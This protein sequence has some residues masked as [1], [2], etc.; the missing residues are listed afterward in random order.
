MDR[1]L[2]EGGDFDTGWEVSVSVSLR[3]GVARLTHGWAWHLG[4]L[5]LETWQNWQPVL[6]PVMRFGRHAA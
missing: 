2:F 3:V 1:V 4:P 5:T 6:G